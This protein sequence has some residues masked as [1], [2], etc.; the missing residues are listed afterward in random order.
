MFV[1]VRKTPVPQFEDTDRRVLEEAAVPP[2][3]CSKLRRVATSGSRPIDDRAEIVRSDRQWD[4][5]DSAGGDRPRPHGGA[6]AFDQ[7]EDVNL[8]MEPHPFPEEFQ[9]SVFARP[10][11][12]QHEIGHRLHC[13][14]STHRPCLDRIRRGLEGSAERIH[15]HGVV[16]DQKQPRGFLFIHGFGISI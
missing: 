5:R 16:A 2:V 7:R 4:P 9:I 14:L 12:E 6:I 11:D 13:A 3:S 1:D 8:R 15:A 10:D